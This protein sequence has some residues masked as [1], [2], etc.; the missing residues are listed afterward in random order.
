MNLKERIQELCKQNNISMNKV[1]TDLEFGK[2]YIS[3]LGKSTPNAI[4]IQKIAD[5][6]EVPIEYL[7]KGDVSD[8]KTPQLKSQ[9]KKDIN[10]F[11]P[12]IRAAAR[13]MM[14]LSPEDQKTA[15]DMINYLSQKGKEAK[16]E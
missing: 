15:I 10:E 16:K 11:S 9:D 3:K 8:N 4:K 13:G 6:F 5:Y 2:G 12:E 7:M 1:E 14:E